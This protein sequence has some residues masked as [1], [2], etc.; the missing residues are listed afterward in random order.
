VTAAA[1]SEAEPRKAISLFKHGPHQD[2]RA[3][4]TIHGCLVALVIAAACAALPASASAHAAPRAS[5]AAGSA[6]A[7]STTLNYVIRFYPR[8][9]T[10]FT[11]TLGTVNSLSGPARM[12]PAYGIVVAPND[13]TIY[14][15]FNLDLSQGPQIFTVRRTNVV[16]SLLTLDVWG[17]VLHTTI[18]SQTPG[19]YA[20]VPSGW[21]GTIPR[22]VTKVEVPYRYTV[23][24]IRADKYA[25]SGQ[26]TTAAAFR[27]RRSLRLA[28][29]S[30]WEHDR[31]SGP[32]NVLPLA[33][34]AP[35]LKAIADEGIQFQPTSFLQR[36]QAGMHSST[37][38]PLSASDVLLSNAFDQAFE[39]ATLAA[40][41]GDYEPMSQVAAAA[42]AAHAT[43]VDRWRSHV[44]PTRWVY[45]DNIGEWGNN[46][47]DR[48]AL[49]EYIQYGNN[50]S[51]AR[52][53]DAFTDHLGVPLDGLVVHSYRLTFT[54]D[55]IPQAKRFWSLT[56]YIPP[57]VT[58]FPN[59]AN[60]YLVGSYT[61]GLKT[62]PNG[63]ITIYIQS[64]PPIRARRA[65]WLPVPRGPFSL[66]LR[67]YG[68]TGNTA[69]GSYV[70]PP[71]SPYGQF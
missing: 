57:G 21:Q 28:S 5:A 25:S 30:A 31:S 11:Q 32:T 13:D 24:I 10:Y 36:L 6:T 66:L 29:L 15:E 62:N 55:Q 45:F 61:P 69:D 56:A 63:S 34:F 38:A 7:Y 2:R 65:N 40:T 23:W 50:A 1:A 22:G 47:L 70:P 53:Y 44:G 48:A 49:T 17:N 52:Y 4:Q 12:G 8:F 43:I 18:N 58:L 37:T 26:S 60:K 19:T 14:A 20:L 68:P 33:L 9:F 71:I 3:R 64:K 16:Y 39:G 27:F 67:V 35:K 46:Y 41:Q 59:R 51:A 54:K 42:Q